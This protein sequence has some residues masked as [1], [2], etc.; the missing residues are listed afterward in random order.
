MLEQGLIVEPRERPA[1]EDDD[2]RRRYYRITSFGAAV[3]QAPRRGGYR[4]GSDGAGRWLRTATSLMAFYDLLLRLYPASF[5]H[6]YGDEMRAIF[7]Q[8]QRGGER[9]FG[10]MSLWIGDGVRGRRQRG[11]C[12]IWTSSKQDLAYTARMLARAPGFAITAILIVALGIG[13][14]TAA[15]SVTDFVLIRPLPVSRRRPPGE[16]W[17]KTPGYSRMELSAPNYRDWKAAAKSFESMGVY[18][19]GRSR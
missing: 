8:R 9:A 5:R 1:P 17:E 4:T 6:E 7:A 18:S 19:T 14:T 10:R 3:A 11:R 13:A 2:E 15:F 12:R 16:V